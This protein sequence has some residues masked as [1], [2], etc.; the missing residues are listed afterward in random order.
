M[1]R[2]MPRMTTA[3]AFAAMMTVAAPM[4]FA[5]DTNTAAPMTPSATHGSVTTTQLQPGQIRGT[6]MKGAE[7]YDNR[8]GKIANVK[9][10]IL[11][12][13]GRIEQ[14]VL[15][16][17]GKDVAV[18]MSELTIA[19]DHKNKPRIAVEMTNDQLKAAQP[20]DPNT[21]AASG[22]SAPPRRPDN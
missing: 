2:M 11:D 14:V 16:V 12:R 1:P 13:H 17:D 20:F 22:S 7:V 15:D 5:A 18:D 9:D 3:A 8:D 4:G 21:R 19:T 6:D 10:M